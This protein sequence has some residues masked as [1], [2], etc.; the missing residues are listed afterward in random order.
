VKRDHAEQ[1]SKPRWG[2]FYPQ[3]IEI[4]RWPFFGQAKISMPCG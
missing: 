4:F 3:G 2:V 1:E